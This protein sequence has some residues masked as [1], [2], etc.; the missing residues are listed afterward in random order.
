TAGAA[1]VVLISDRLWRAQLS[2]DP[3][4]LGRTL[5]LDGLTATI[6]GVLPPDF[7]SVDPLDVLEPV[8]VYANGNASMKDRGSR[9]DMRVVAR[10]TA[11]MSLERARTEMAAVGAQLAAAYPSTND[12]FGVDVQA[13]RDTFVSTLRPTMR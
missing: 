9:S 11:D 10:L 12:Q 7:R 3:H 5:T 13:I 8:G 2:G 1:P 6:I 4:A